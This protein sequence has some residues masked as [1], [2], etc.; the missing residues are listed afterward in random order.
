M[1][2][3]G[4]V[5]TPA[6]PADALPAPALQ[7]RKVASR[8]PERVGREKTPVEPAPEIA[9]E[10]AASTPV[11]VPGVGYLVVQSRP[12]ARLTIDGQEAGR[13]TPIPAANPVVL[14][15]GSH[16]LVLETA[17]GRR[18]EEQVQIEPGKTARLVRML[19]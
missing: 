8:K 3:D 13:W 14:P 16:T 15:A 2:L 7:P 9:R 4:V 10:V 6:P 12:A 18:L 5:L 11:A 19:P 1:Q 17:D